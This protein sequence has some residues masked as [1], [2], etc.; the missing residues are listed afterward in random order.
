MMSSIDHSN[1]RTVK[2][3]RIPI[4]TFHLMIH[5]NSDF[6]SFFLVRRGFQRNV[7]VA[8]RERAGVV[9]GKGVMGAGG[10]WWELTNSVHEV[11]LFEI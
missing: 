2:E 4:K 3:A 10:N 8:C 5:G 1:Y 6:V 7:T 11:K 9:G